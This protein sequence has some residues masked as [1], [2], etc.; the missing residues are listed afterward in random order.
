MEQWKPVVGFENRYE[1][2]DCGNVRSINWRNLGIV[3]NLYLKRHNRGYLKVELVKDGVKKTF[4]VH[5]LVAEAFVKNEEG[6]DCVNHIDEDKTNNSASNL[7]WC[8]RKYNANYSASR[9][10]ERFGP[11]RRG[12]TKSKSIVQMTIDGNVVGEWENAREIFLKTGMSAWSITECCR[13]HRNKA[14]GFKWQY[15]IE[16]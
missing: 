9:H 12:S 3:R 14:Y 1:V 16:E 11:N 7:E 2:S 4:C 8:N 15:A 13:G 5:R 6:F 10:P